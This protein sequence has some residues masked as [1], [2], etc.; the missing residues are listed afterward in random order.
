MED[1]AIVELYF[2]RDQR[3]IR[4]T[5][6]KYGGMCHRLAYRI[7]GD[8]RDAEE[9][10]SDTWLCAWKVIPPQRPDPL[11]AWLCRVAR[12]LALKKYRDGHAARVGLSEKNVS[13]RLTRLRK[14]LKDFLTES[15]VNV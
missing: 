11:G 13:V 12:N 15:G 1:S 3:A 8:R 5:D 14:R 4:E 7:L 10:V 6:T 2:A 9:C